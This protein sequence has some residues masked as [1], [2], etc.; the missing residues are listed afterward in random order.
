MGGCSLRAAVSPAGPG[1]VKAVSRGG[2]GGGFQKSGLPPRA[3][4]L[5][6]RNMKALLPL[7]CPAFM[8]FT[9]A[10]G[11]EEPRVLFNGKNFE[12]WEFDIISSKVEPGEIWSV[13]DGMIVCQGRPLSVVRTEEEFENFEL[14]LE[15][16]WAPDGKPGNSGVLVHASKPR[17][18]SIWP[19]SIEV[20]LAHESAGDFW[21]IGETIKVDGRE[22]IGRRIPNGGTAAEKPVG[23]WNELRVRCVGT[24]IT[25]HVNGVLM[26]EGRNASATRGAICLQSEGAEAHFRNIR[27]SKIQAP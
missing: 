18:R 9:Q 15:W 6:N 23:E 2:G 7:L 11:A 14:T 21:M 3:G 10:F 5:Q 8:I 4:I 13:R 17:E 20:Q 25:V 24:T 26:N 27:I 16:R 19:K 22:P 12:G 1:K